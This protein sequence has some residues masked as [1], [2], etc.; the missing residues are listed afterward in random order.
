MKS[1][2]PRYGILVMMVPVLAI[3]AV[4]S[5]QVKVPVKAPILLIRT[6]CGTRALAP[7]HFDITDTLRISDSEAGPFSLRPAGAYRSGSYTV[8]V[9][10]DTM[11]GDEPVL[12]GNS[13]TGTRPIYRVTGLSF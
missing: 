7:A 13:L 4:V 8:I 6:Q 12:N 1:L 2:I 3:A 10:C 5:T 9:S 11:P